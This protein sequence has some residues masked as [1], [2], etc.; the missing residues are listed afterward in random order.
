[1]IPHLGLFLLLFISVAKIDFCCGAQRPELQILDQDEQNGGSFCPGS[2]V[3]LKCIF[4]ED[5]QALAWYVSGSEIPI[6]GK[7]L[8]QKFQ[9]HSVQS[10]LE[11]GYTVVNIS[12]EEPYRA[13][14]SCAVYHISDN[15]VSNS[16]EVIFQ[17]TYIIL[18]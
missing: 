8:P 12:K 11:G 15:V 4:P 1:M 18:H 9:G 13:N 2:T 16:V 10:S 5:R 3:R 17:G 6:D 7:Y 14:Y